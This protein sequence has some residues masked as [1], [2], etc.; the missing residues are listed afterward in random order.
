MCELKVYRLLCKVIEIEYY[1]SYYILVVLYCRAILPCNGIVC[2]ILHT[3]STVLLPMVNRLN[4]TLA[5]TS[6]YP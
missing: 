1:L 2:V 4:I 6:L 3:G 5:G